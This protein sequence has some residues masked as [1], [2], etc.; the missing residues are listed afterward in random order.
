MLFW[1]FTITP[2][3]ALE[4]NQLDINRSFAVAVIPVERVGDSSELIS[5]QWPYKDNDFL[6]PSF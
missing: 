2:E 3:R 6:L 5:N 1:L 4:V